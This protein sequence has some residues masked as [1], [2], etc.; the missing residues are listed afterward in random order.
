MFSYAVGLLACLLV[1]YNPLSQLL[2][3]HSPAAPP[4]IRRTSKPAINESLLALDDWAGNLTCGE[5]RYSVHLFSKEPLII[6]IEGFLSKGERSHLLDIRLVVNS[7][8]T[9]G[10]IGNYRAPGSRTAR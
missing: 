6:Y 5:D 8:R 1:L 10:K 2:V 9:S 7:P 3:G 4:Q